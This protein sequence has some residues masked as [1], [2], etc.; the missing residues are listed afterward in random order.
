[1]PQ[2]GGGGVA[3]AFLGLR[4]HVVGIAAALV[5]VG[6]IVLQA[7]TMN[8]HYLAHEGS[9]G[10]H[11]G[12]CPPCR[13]PAS[14]SAGAVTSPPCPDPVDP[15]PCP[16][17]VVVAKDERR[18]CPEPKPCPRVEAA[19]GSSSLMGGSRGLSGFANQHGAAPPAPDN[20]SGAC[21]A[22]L[23][24]QWKDHYSLAKE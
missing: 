19:V 9:G 21:G 12:P 17:A 20:T 6:V 22:V 16:P 10:D 24:E 13:F 18:P 2:R 11:G 3:G 14:A 1:M 4:R 15:A 8:L 7:V 5:L 23:Y